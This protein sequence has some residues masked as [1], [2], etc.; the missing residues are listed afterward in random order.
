MPRAHT[1]L[2]SEFPYSVGARCINRE[3]FRIPMKTVWEIM[4]SHLFFMHHGFG[5]RI[6]SFVLMSNHFH[7][8]L[9]TPNANL[10]EAMQYFMRNTSRELTRAGNRINQSYGGRYFRC[11]IEEDHYYLHAYKYF[12]RNPVVAGLC[13]NVEDY[14]FST[15]S[16]LLGTNHLLIPLVEDRQLLT[17]PK[18]TLQW[19][20]TPSN[21]ENWVA[22]GNSLKRKI[23]YFP[24]DG[25]TG[26]LHPLESSYL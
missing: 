22:V 13:E 11:L 10:S 15:L 12:Y 1:I 8:L 23:F 9:T 26:G 14:P 18:A 24:K 25:R 21:A 7:L 6:H 16:G 19:L 2:Q 4:C 3:W 17:D 5:V 20:N